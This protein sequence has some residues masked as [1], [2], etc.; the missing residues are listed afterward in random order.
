MVKILEI[1]GLT[2]SFGNLVALK[3]IYLTIEQG[4]ILGLIGPNGAGKSTLVNLISGTLS[5]SAGDIRFL[6]KSIKG[7]KPHQIAE[8]GISRTSQIVRPFNDMTTFEN[9]MVGAL[10]G[11]KGKKKGM[12]VARR[13]AKGILQD[14]GLTGRDEM[15]AESLNIAE[16]KRLENARAVAMLPNLLLLDEVL[17]GLNPVEMDDGVKLIKRIRDSGV[18]II[19]IEHVMRAIADAC[20]R[21]LVLN[22]GEKI[23][24]GGPDMVLNHPDVIDAYLGKRYNALVT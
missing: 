1:H 19:V 2:K 20:D 11:K 13:K 12:R 6:G 8:L 21:V 22:H 23:T 14:L 15:P 16:R 10:F 7:F 18:T 4:E 9:I 24:E 3:D 5:Y 17:A